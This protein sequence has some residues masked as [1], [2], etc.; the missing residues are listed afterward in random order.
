MKYTYFD[1]YYM[2]LLKNFEKQPDEYTFKKWQ[3]TSANISQGKHQEF[4]QVE[5]FLNLIKLLSK[6][7]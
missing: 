5:I 1:G 3:F 4:F 6:I 2:S 7:N